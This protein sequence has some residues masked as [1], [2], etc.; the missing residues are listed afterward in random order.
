MLFNTGYGV[1]AFGYL[2]LIF[3]LLTVRKK[4]LTKNLLLS[5]TVVTFAWALAH[6]DLVNWVYEMRQYTQLDS[7]RMWIWALFLSA[8]LQHNTTQLFELIRRPHTYMMLVFPSISVLVAFVPIVS[9]SL[10]YL[11]VTLVTVQILVVLEQVFRQ[12]G[13]QKWAYKPL[14]IYLGALTT[15]DF[16]T[17]ANAA[18]INAVD[19]TFFVA[20][21]YVYII[22]LPFLVLAIRRIQTWGIEIFVSRE[23][24]LHSTLLILSGSYLMVMAMLGYL[25][26]YFG[27]EWGAPVQIVLFLV[28]IVLLFSL[29]ASNEFRTKLKIF[30]SKNFYANQFDYRVEWLALTQTLSTE[31]KSLSQV[32]EIALQGWAKSIKYE[33]GLLVKLQGQYCVDVATINNATTGIAANVSADYAALVSYFQHKSWI[34]DVDEMRVKPQLYNDLSIRNKMIAAFPYQL[35]VPIYKQNELWGMVLLNAAGAQK[36]S[37]NWEIRDYLIAVTEQTGNFLFQAESAQALTEN[38]QFAAFNRMSAFVVHDLKN[39]LAQINL[40]LANAKQHKNNPEFIDDTFETL[41]HTKA[42]MDKMLKQLMD[43]SADSG[44]TK[45]NT[46]VTELLDTLISSKCAGILPIPVLT[47]TTAFY[48]VIDSDKLANVMYHLIDNAQ[49]ATAD[50]GSVNLDISSNDTHIIVKITDTG[51]GMSRLFIDNKLFKPFETTKGNAG[52]GVGAYDAKTFLQGIGGNLLVESEEGA[53]TCFS[54]FI[55]LVQDD[56]NV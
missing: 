46:N 50:D 9:P 30:I 56:G 3:L 53:G 1:T 6:L 34:I 36:R 44:A 39:V 27:G 5:A 17:Y 54:V 48:T 31:N 2:L 13:E 15:F 55:P 8:C 11:L 40:L 16:F 20:R 52:M 26:N 42:R 51:V 18:M 14:I 23:V 32:Y 19:W 28:A 21:G 12:S 33:Q 47:T 41:E 43:K 7:I 24:V 10:Q 22:L 49:Q 4:S 38:A 25:V 35:I 45:Q 37:L 29:F